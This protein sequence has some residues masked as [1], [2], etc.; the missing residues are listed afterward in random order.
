MASEKT[1]DSKIE[2]EI[3][4]KIAKKDFSGLELLIE[5]YSF[6]IRQVIWQT[7]G[8]KTKDLGDLE[9]E[10]YFKLWQKIPLFNPQKASLK[11]WLETVVKNHVLDYLRKNQLQQED[12]S[13][14]DVDQTFSI[15]DRPLEKEDFLSLLTTLKPLD[16]EIFYRYYFYEESA[17]E[18]AEVLKLKSEK[19]Y[20]RLSRGRKK[21]A[22]ALK[23]GAF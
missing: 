8:H 15:S 7:L 18:I 10:I 17:A 3:C 12:L 20:N 6:H 1:V 22:K 13:I 9:N 4:Q 23:K 19:V 11:T 2:E 16:Q 5:T 21:L 14:E